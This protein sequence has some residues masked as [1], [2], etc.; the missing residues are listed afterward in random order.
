MWQE[1]FLWS[2]P[3][4]SLKP[5]ACL[6]IAPIIYISADTH[7]CASWRLVTA[8]SYWMVLMQSR[9]WP[10][11]FA[12][13]H[14]S[15]SSPSLV[16][17]ATSDSSCCKIEGLPTTTRSWLS[18]TIST[19][20]RAYLPLVL[21]GKR[22]VHIKLLIWWFYWLII[23]DS[24]MYGKLH[25]FPLSQIKTNLTLQSIWPNHPNSGHPCL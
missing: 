12:L 22:K 16:R 5:P 20:I 21:C 14:A 18:R 1:E 9:L 24:Q 13:L 19:E 2:Q 7:T 15:D 10:I 23:I 17:S 6:H 4:F 8:R 11:E 3:Q 25:G